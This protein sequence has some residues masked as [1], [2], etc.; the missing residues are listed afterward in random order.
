[1]IGQGF[2]SHGSVVYRIYQM[3]VTPLYYFL[4]VDRCLIR[5][6]SIHHR[7][8]F[9]GDKKKQPATLGE[10][11]CFPFESELNLQCCIGESQKE[12]HLEQTS[13]KLVLAPKT[14]ETS[15]DSQAL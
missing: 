5:D 7:K 2:I 15:R 8:L 13:C 12:M 4:Q 10:S 3:P 6:S 14:G 9:S 1:M 11:D